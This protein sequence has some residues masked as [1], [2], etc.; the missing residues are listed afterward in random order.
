[1]IV[2]ATHIHDVLDGAAEDF[3][4]TLK[5]RAAAAHHGPHRS[6]SR[7]HAPKHK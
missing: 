2:A 6:H 1:M 3:H 7:S 5:L 4:R